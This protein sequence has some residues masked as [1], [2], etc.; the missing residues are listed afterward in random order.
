MTWPRH[1]KERLLL[2]NSWFRPLISL[3]SSHPSHSW[4]NFIPNNQGS[5]FS[6]VVPA[7][8]VEVTT[9]KEPRVWVTS[10]THW[11]VATT[12]ASHRIS[13]TA[14][15]LTSR[16]RGET[17]PLAIIMPLR[18]LKIS[19]YNQIVQM[20]IMAAQVA[21]EGITWPQGAS[22]PIKIRLEM[23]SL[24]HLMKIWKLSLSLIFTRVC[25]PFCRSCSRQIKG[26]LLQPVHL[27]T[28]RAP[29][30]LSLRTKQTSL[31]QETP[32]NHQ[33][34]LQEDNLLSSH[35]SNPSGKLR[36]TTLSSDSRTSS[37]GHMEASQHCRMMIP[38]TNTK[39]TCFPHQACPI[40]HPSL[41]LTIRW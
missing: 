38:L 23:L 29:K 27:K 7:G 19:L 10:R 13:G 9:T 39:V 30:F 8:Q 20:R 15:L 41:F 14:L 22:T 32:S 12:L 28:T 37:K 34:W 40:H 6:E 5:Q 11:L 31:I 25:T 3:L 35:R 24:V 1:G 26:M 21:L 33:Q 18:L 4:I 16:N 17:R 2:K 36:V